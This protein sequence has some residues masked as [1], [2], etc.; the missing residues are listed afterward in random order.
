MNVTDRA[1]LFQ[2][3]AVAI[4]ELRAFKPTSKEEVSKWYQLGR[5][6]EAMLAKPDGL[7]PEVPSILWHYLFDADTRFKSGK[8][9]EL[10]DRQMRLLVR[11]LRRGEMPSN[12]E[13][14]EHS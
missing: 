13:L 3:L 2:E 8:Y 14:R 9:A 7:S 10:Q 6:V 12:D 11:Y 5:H 4:E 1:A